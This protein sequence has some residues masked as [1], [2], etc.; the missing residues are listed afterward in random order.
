MLY[1][2][3]YKLGEIRMRNKL[4][5]YMGG[6]RPN[7]MTDKI[8]ELI[9]FSSKRPKESILFVGEIIVESI[10]TVMKKLGLKW[11]VYITMDYDKLERNCFAGKFKCWENLK[12]KNK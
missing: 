2:T 4:E 6:Y 8:L 3:G 7:R 10:E 9:D 11:H 5:F 12:C 1:G